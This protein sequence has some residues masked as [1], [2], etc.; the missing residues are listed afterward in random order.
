MLRKFV[1][2][3]FTFGKAEAD[4]DDLRLDFNKAEAY[5]FEAEAFDK[6][7]AEF[8]AKVREREK[9]ERKAYA[10]EVVNAFFEEMDRRSRS[11]GKSPDNSTGS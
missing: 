10:Q 1:M 7:A 6:E 8:H 3:L 11:R 2:D 9:A 5:A 4:G